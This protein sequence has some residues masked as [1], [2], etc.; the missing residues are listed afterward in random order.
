M[1]VKETLYQK[2]EMIASLNEDI[3]LKI[4]RMQLIQIKLW[5]SPKIL[6]YCAAAL[7][8]PVHHLYHN[9]YFHSTGKHILLYHCLRLVTRTKLTIII[10][11]LSSVLL[12]K[13]LEQ[14][15]YN[16]LIDHY[17]QIHS[18]IP[19]WVPLWKILYTTAIVSI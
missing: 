5:V 3:Q 15:V 11:F 1:L 19:V 10:P 7:V 13:F 9:N 4:H 16:K 6:K 12:Q 14:L 2:V 17:C 8:Q 18:S